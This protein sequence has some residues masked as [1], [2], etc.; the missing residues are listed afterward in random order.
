MLLRKIIKNLKLCKDLIQNFKMIGLLY[1]YIQPLVIITT[2]LK[3]KCCV[4]FG[5]YKYMS[6]TKFSA[7]KMADEVNWNFP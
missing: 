5:L 6:S 7:C 1:F 2:D 4:G 3:K